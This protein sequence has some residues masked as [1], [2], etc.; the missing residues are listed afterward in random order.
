[1]IVHQTA[2]GIDRTIDYVDRTMADYRHYL[3]AIGSHYPRGI[4]L[5]T[6]ATIGVGVGVIMAMSIIATMAVI[7]APT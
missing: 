2:F 3:R 7:R 6:I 4:R 5:A 1:M